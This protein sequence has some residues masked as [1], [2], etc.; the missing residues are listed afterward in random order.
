MHVSITCAELR[1]FLIPVIL[2]G[3]FWVSLRWSMRISHPGE[4][5]EFPSSAALI[6]SSMSDNG[7]LQADVFC[8][9]K[10]LLVL[11]TVQFDVNTSDRMTKERER[12]RG[13]ETEGVKKKTKQ[14]FS[15]L[16][17]SLSLPPP[18][19]NG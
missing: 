19:M 4:E 5:S 9:A 10:A 2:P 15:P 6:L 18:K 17:L 8:F 11:H 13:R 12:E 7:S 3:V 16:S 14:I 1:V